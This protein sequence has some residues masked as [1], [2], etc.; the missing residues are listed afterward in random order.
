MPRHS[1]NNTA[2]STF[3]YYERQ[4]ANKSYGS[5]TQRLSALSQRAFDACNLCLSPARDPVCC[6]AQGHLYC[7]ECVYADLLAQKREIERQRALLAQLEEEEELERSK[8]LEKARERVLR[9]FERN[10]VGLAL[11]G[12]SSSRNGSA[13]TQNGG[14]GNALKRK[15]DDSEPAPASAPFS[16]TNFAQRAEELTR[17]AEE[18]AL[19]QIQAEQLA[20]RKERKLPSF[21]LP[22]LTPSERQDAFARLG[23]TR[24]GAKSADAEAGRAGASSLKDLELKTVCRAGVGNERG[25]ALRCERYLI[26]WSRAD[27]S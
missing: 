18:T 11:G 25:H 27:T 7:K 14:T 22:E 23:L 21:W 9:E 20:A 4:L 6:A 24:P 12:S 5:A 2:S 3:T 16:S 15:A 8:A 17:K 13:S 10:S 26:V 19:Q 1:K